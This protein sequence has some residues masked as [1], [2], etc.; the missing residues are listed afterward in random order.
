M[1]PDSHDSTASREVSCP[2]FN[3]GMCQTRGVR[4]HYNVGSVKFV[5]ICSY[6]MAADGIRM[7]THGA[8]ACRK[9][10]RSPT[11]ANVPA[12]ECNISQLQQ[13][14]QPVSTV[15]LATTG[16]LHTDTDISSCPKKRI[17]CTASPPS[18]LPAHDK[19]APQSDGRLEA[20]TSGLARSE[21]QHGSRRGDKQHCNIDRSDAAKTE[22]GSSSDCYTQNVGPHIDFMHKIR[23]HATSIFHQ[24][25]SR[26]TVETIRRPQTYAQQISI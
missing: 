7:D 5:H 11:S 10:Q 8:P 19:Q 21:A 24:A 15:Q 25:Y 16:C 17:E 4:K 23:C 6:C 1:G 3:T 9:K 22:P 20:P 26:N 13:A 12:P 18:H 14:I 2:D